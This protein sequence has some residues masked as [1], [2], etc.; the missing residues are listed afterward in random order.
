MQVCH[1]YTV[2]NI[3]I[4]PLDLAL[5]H[6]WLHHDTIIWLL[7]NSMI[8]TAFDYML[9][10]EFFQ[11]YGRIKSQLQKQIWSCNTKSE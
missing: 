1:Y 8:D 10:N 7:N 9:N 11:F 5:Q 3:Y 2:N 4:D 6:I